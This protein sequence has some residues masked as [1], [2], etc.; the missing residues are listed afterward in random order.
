MIAAILILGACG[1][2]ILMMRRKKKVDVPAT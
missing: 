2:R 1:F